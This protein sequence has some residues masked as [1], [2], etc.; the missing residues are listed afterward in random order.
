MTGAYLAGELARGVGRRHLVVAPIAIL[1]GILSAFLVPLLP[2]HALSALRRTLGFTSWDAVVQYT[3]YGMLFQSLFW[4][5]VFDAAA[6]Y[7]TPFQQRRLQLYL[8]KPITRSAYLYAKAMSSFVALVAFGLVVAGCQF[9]AMRV[10]GVSVGLRAFAGGTTVV[11]AVALFLLALLGLLDLNVKRTC[12]AV[13]IGVGVWLGV[14][15][16]KL[17]LVGYLQL[18]RA[19]PAA[20]GASAFPANPVWVA[21]EILKLSPFITPLL[22]LEALLLVFAAA[23]KLKRMDL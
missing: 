4:V 9:V 10:L 2:E 15:L 19:G 16:P 21:D 5:G 22:L 14:M 1:G 18:T 20:A 6:A 8:S 3:M 12:H 7:A 13:L 11:I 17:L 23:L